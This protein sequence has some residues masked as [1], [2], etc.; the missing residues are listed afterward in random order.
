MSPPTTA[1]GILANASQMDSVRPSV[2][3]APSI[4]KAAVAAPNTKPG[5]KL[6]ASVATAATGVD[7][8][9]ITCVIP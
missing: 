3:V 2:W 5:G 9:V 4:W 8:G 6:L 7:C 1:P